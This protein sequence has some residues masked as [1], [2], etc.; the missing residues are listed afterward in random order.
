MLGIIAVAEYMPKPPCQITKEAC[1]YQH[2]LEVTLQVFF[3]VD[4]CSITK[5]FQ[6]VSE[7]IMVHFA[8]NTWGLGLTG[9]FSR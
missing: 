7:L 2:F 5:S 4:F 6:V 8:R 1:D 9:S 3:L